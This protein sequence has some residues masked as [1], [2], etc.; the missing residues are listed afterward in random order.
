MSKAHLATD[1]ARVV[2]IDEMTKPIITQM[3]SDLVGYEFNLNVSSRII[4]DIPFY[5]EFRKKTDT[6]YRALFEETSGRSIEEDEKPKDKGMSAQETDLL[7]EAIRKYRWAISIESKTTNSLYTYAVVDGQIYELR[8][9]DH[10]KDHEQFGNIRSVKKMEDGVPLKA[11]SVI[12]YG[13][14]SY[15]TPFKTTVKRLNGDKAVFLTSK[16]NELLEKEA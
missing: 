9:S 2:V 12:K 8:E 15:S 10:S 1:G 3:I 13:I 7:V 4:L 14:V 11:N 16:L 5:H 6:L